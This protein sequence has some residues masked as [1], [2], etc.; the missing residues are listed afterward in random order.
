MTRL[1]LLG[2]LGAGLLG[3]IAWELAPSHGDDGLPVAAARRPPLP[4]ATA[5]EGQAARQDWVA[6]SLARPIF[7]PDR[8]PAP[9]AASQAGGT[10]AAEPPRLTGIMITPTGSHAIFAAGERL[11]VVAEGAVVGG[12][13]VTRI[14]GDQVV[15][16]G[17]LG[18]RSLR[19]SFSAA[20][21]AA[22]SAAPGTAPAFAAMPAPS[23]LDI[24]R[25]AARQAG[26]AN[27]AAGGPVPGVD[28]TLTGPI[29]APPQ[30]GRPGG[31]PIR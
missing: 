26:S 16:T 31:T 1:W 3:V 9:V 2:V 6:T 11:L 23:G 24:L 27:P 28:Q 13:T 15:V 22:P 12:F 25:N 7:S 20:G 4:Q 14:A 21:A 8:R 10:A 5:V 17:P 29:A 30:P 18:S 19:P